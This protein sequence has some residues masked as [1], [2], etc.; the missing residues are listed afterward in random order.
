MAT[1]SIQ[2]RHRVTGRDGAP[3]HRDREL[4]AGKMGRA[5]VGAHVDV[6]EADGVGGRPEVK[7][8]PVE[9]PIHRADDRAAIRGDR[10]QRQQ[11]HPGQPLCHLLGAE[12]PL[13]RVDAPQVRAR[14]LVAAVEQFLQ[15]GEVGR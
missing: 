4:L 2:M 11:A 12:P 3:V 1:H 7:R 5:H 10:G 15:A 6:P 8:A 13:R 14:R 9:D